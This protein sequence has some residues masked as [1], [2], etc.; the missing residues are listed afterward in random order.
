MDFGLAKLAEDKDLVQK[1]ATQGTQASDP[2]PMARD[3]AIEKSEGVTKID[4]GLTRTGASMGTADYMSPEQVRKE[5]L[6]GRSDLFSF[7]LVLYEASA[8]RRAFTG[9]T[10]VTIDDAILHETPVRARDL[11]A[12]VPRGLDAVIAKALEKERALRYHSSAEMCKELER[13]R[14]ETQPWRRQARNWAAAGMLLV[15][16][17]IGLGIYARSRNRVRLS[18]ND[19]IVL[20]VDN[21]TGD[22]VFNDA[23][24]TS[25]RTGLEQT[26]YLSVLGAAKV[27]EVLS[28]LHLSSDPTR[29]TPQMAHDVC[30]RTD[31][32]IVVAA[33]LAEAG[34]DFRI[35]LA[36]IDCRS[37]RI[38]AEDQNDAPGRNQVIG[39]LGESTARLRAKLGEPPDSVSSFNQPLDQATSALPEAIGFLTQGYRHHLAG[40]FREAISFYHR[41]LDVDPNLALAYM[42]LAGALQRLGQDSSAVEAASRAYVLRGRLT[43]QDRFNEEDA[44][45]QFVTGDEE[46]DCEVLSQWVQTYPD[47]FIPHNNFAACLGILGQ[48]DRAL[49]ESREAAR[50][51]PNAFTYD[52]VIGASIRSEQFDAAKTALAAARAR[53]FDYPPLHDTQVLLAFLQKDQAAMEEQWKWAMGKPGADYLLLNGRARVQSYYGKEVESRGLSDQAAGLA[54]REGASSE[55]VFHAAEDAWNE[56]EVG[57]TTQ[58]RRDA[59]KLLDKVQS[60][61]DQILLALVL[62]RAGDTA[63]AQKLLHSLSQYLQSK[64]VAQNYYLPTIRAAMKL[65][66]KD[67]A[68]AIDLLRPVEKYDLAYANAF[69]GVYPAYLRGLAYLQMSQGRLA[70]MEFQKLLDHPGSVGRDITGALSRLQIARAYQLMGDEASARQ[71]YQQFLTL[72]K[73]ADPDLLA[74]QQAKTEYARLRS[75]PKH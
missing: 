3:P 65:N 29:V 35:K 17:A 71:S 52:K 40:D 26:P 5:K 46:K 9:E 15:L 11:N 54:T 73:D 18:R 38:I 33:S 31:S 62:A 27:G 68:G 8:G 12:S 64:S 32:K 30:L 45:H 55:I 63:Q 50:L 25:L 61:D 21:Q 37:G 22:P 24:Y 14:R 66:A 19:T 51:N 36:G 42:G 44:Y 70:A 58:S 13:V 4:A 47:N 34:N 57:H 59:E 53:K 10:S 2:V 28:T 69:N 39:V 23:L 1:L 6:D 72:W 20:A 41:A 56:V 67:P 74:Y 16:L 60:H 7:G 43:V 49:A 75:N 48:P